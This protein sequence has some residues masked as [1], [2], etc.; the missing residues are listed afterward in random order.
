MHENVAIFMSWDA[1]DRIDSNNI[2]ACRT[3]SEI[4]RLCY[5]CV[6]PSVLRANI[7]LAEEKNSLQ[8]NANQ[9]H[10]DQLANWII[11]IYI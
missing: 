9:Y 1:I 11:V 4:L 6:S 3:Q 2:T 8:P 7:N 5:A 10:F